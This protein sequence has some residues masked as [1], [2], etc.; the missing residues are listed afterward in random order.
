MD[1]LYIPLELDTTDLLLLF[2][3]PLPNLLYTPLVLFDKDVSLLY[4]IFVC[5]ISTTTQYTYH[6]RFSWKHNKLI[7]IKIQIFS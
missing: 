1:A 4:Y 5:F 2:N 7:I 3:L 6:E